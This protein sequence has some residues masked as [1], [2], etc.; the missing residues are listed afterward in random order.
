MNVLVA[1]PLDPVAVEEIRAAGLSVTVKTG[2]AK[3]ALVKALDGIDILVVRSATKVTADVLKAAGSLRLVIRGGVG[4]DNIDVE[5]AQARGVTVWNTPE[6]GTHSVAEHALALM[7]A[8]ARRLGQAHLSMK[9]GRW[10]KSKLEGVELKGKTLG[11]IGVGRIGSEVARIALAIGMRVIAHRRDATQARPELAGMGIPIVSFEALLRE[12]DV[13]SLHVPLTDVTR[14]M[15]DSATIAQMKDGVILINCARGGVVDEA[16]LAAAIRS[17]KVSG[18]GVDVFEK[19]PPT[20]NHPLRDLDAVVLTPHLGAS[21]VEGQA[22]IGR[23]VA[24][25]VIA[26]ARQGRN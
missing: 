17:G 23:E 14:H 6:A 24:G 5:A 13:I 15:I 4:L 7:F 8:V 16:A 26:F 20:P 19:E 12:S 10:E 9:A 3:E 21:A 22:R 25:K 1:D 11:L 2:L 18:A